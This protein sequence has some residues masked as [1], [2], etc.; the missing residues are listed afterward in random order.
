MLTDQATF[1]SKTGKF[2]SRICKIPQTYQTLSQFNLSQKT[3]P[4]LLTILLLPSF[5]NTY[6][7]R[8]FLS[9]FPTKLCMRF[10]FTAT[11]TSQN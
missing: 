5:K 3:T 2:L 1:Q 7:S 9:G 11:D 10:L 4:Y 8:D 6:I